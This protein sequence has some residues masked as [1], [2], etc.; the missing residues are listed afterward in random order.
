V[1][2]K[3]LHTQIRFPA[4]AVHRENKHSEGDKL[5]RTPIVINDI[6]LT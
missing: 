6:F 1:F 3:T 5:P 2:S 4:F